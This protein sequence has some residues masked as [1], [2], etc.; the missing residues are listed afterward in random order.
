MEKRKLA[1]EREL[2]R[3]NGDIH[4]ANEL[5]MRLFEL[6]QR[7]SELD[8]VRTSTITSIAYI[9]DRNRR[10]NIE[11]AEK[12]IREEHA[13]SNGRKVNIFLILTECPMEN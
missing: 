6:E 7:A 1:E 10:R 13:A 2:A 8:M 5:G 11:E 4:R 9:N 12:A 3:T